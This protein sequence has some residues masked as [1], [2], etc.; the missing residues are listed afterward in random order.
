M[1]YLFGT[2]AK[3]RT[4]LDGDELEAE[5]NEKRVALKDFDSQKST[6]FAAVG[7]LIA[8]NPLRDEAAFFA[9]YKKRWSSGWCSGES[10]CPKTAHETDQQVQLDMEA[11]KKLLNALEEASSNPN[12]EIHFWESAKGFIESVEWSEPFILCVMAFH[13]CF[14]VLIF[15][16]GKRPH[17]EKVL[18]GLIGEVQSVNDKK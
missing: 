6:S 5:R 3:D 11:I 4:Q 16:S 18:F 8:I 9:K 15:V 14:Y 17:L 2:Y 12:E 7:T 13:L 1:T 10:L